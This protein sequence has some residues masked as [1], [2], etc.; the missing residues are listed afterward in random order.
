[1]KSIIRYTVFAAVAALLLGC[2]EK[3]DLEDE[4]IDEV[5]RVLKKEF[6]E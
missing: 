4:T 1:M 2:S 5:I 6:E 3:A